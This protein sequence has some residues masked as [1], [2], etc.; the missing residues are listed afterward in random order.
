MLTIKI[1][2]IVE[3]SKEIGRLSEYLSDLDGMREEETRE[4]DKKVMTGHMESFDEIGLEMCRLHCERIVAE[5]DDN[6]FTHKKFAGRLDE[7]YH[8]MVDE[9]HSI[10]FIVLT[11]SEKSLFQQVT[12][13]FG[14]EV[15]D[16]L[17]DMSEDIAEAGKCLAL[18]RSTASVFHLMRAME[19]AVQKFGDKLGVPLVDEKVW[20]VILDGINAKIRPMGKSA[21]G[22]RYAEISSYLYNVKLAW[23]NETM[24]PKATYTDEE[25]ESIFQ[26]VKTFMRELVAVL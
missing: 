9:C 2:R 8:R 16:K 26:A 25:A 6:L 14:N 1:Q 3:L 18:R 15:E 23:R 5:L 19:I 20:Q 22:K 11:S 24:H 12:P 13:L 7:L 4:S 21:D 10:H 17:P